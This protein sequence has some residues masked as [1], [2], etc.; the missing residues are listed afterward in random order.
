M[1]WFVKQYKN[2]TRKK[3]WETSQRN[4]KKNTKSVEYCIEMSINT[5][6]LWHVLRTD[7]FAG[8]RNSVFFNSIIAVDECHDSMKVQTSKKLWPKKGACNV[9]VLQRLNSA[10]YRCQNAGCIDKNNFPTLIQVFRCSLVKTNVLLSYTF[11]INNINTITNNSIELT[12]VASGLSIYRF[13]RYD[14]VASNFPLQSGSKLL[15]QIV[16]S[17]SIVFYSCTNTTLYFMS[18][19]TFDFIRT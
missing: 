6:L 1:F 14:F 7:L 9:N 4:A 5:E 2:L 15:C 11:N 18:S 17:G 8:Q 10:F 3:E 16:A 12:L 13:R 19:T